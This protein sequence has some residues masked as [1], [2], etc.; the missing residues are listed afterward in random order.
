MTPHLQVLHAP[1]LP[2]TAEFQD[3]DFHPKASVKAV[4]PATPLD[5]GH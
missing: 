5:M 1:T 3:G 4:S 2:R